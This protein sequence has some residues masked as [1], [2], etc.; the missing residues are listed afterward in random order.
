MATESKIDSVHFAPLNSSNYSEW[1]IRM[2]AELVRRGLFKVVL[3]R[4]PASLSG[5]DVKKETKEAAWKAWK[6]GRDEDKMAEARAEM[7]LRVE[8]SQLSHM[9]DDDPMV[10]WQELVRV[11]VARGL[12]TRLALR[13]QFIKMSK[14]GASMADWIARMKAAAFRLQRIGVAITDEDGILTLTNGLDES[15]DSFVISLDSTPTEQLTLD[16]V[17]DRLLN[18][19]VQRANRDDEQPGKDLAYAARGFNQGG[20]GQVAGNQTGQ[21]A[22]DVDRSCWR[23]GKFGH[24]KLFCQEVPEGTGSRGAGKSYMA[25]TDVTKLRVMPEDRMP[26]EVL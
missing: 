24:I 3:W 21:G 22:G 1:S 16:Y 10:I 12:A 18:E 19:E 26:G 6:A 15:Y 25:M 2:E 14:G 4:P 5:P 17:I 13:R 23:C 9:R 7:I 8:D 11:H 20:N